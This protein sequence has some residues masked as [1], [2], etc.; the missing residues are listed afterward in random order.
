[1]PAR[2]PRACAAVLGDDTHQRVGISRVPAGVADVVV[3]LVLGIPAEHHV[4]EAEALVQGGEEFLPG[5]VLAA[6]DPVDVEYADFDVAELALLDDA[7]GVPCGANLTGLHV[8]LLPMS[9]AG[10]VS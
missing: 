2:P 4:A 8:D 9:R 3:E 5:H 1:M 7:A 6:Q 10:I